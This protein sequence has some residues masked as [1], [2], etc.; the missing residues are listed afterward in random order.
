MR[1][2]IRVPIS[3]LTVNPFSA[4]TKGKVLSAWLFLPLLDRLALCFV[5][6]IFTNNARRVEIAQLFASAIELIRKN[7]SLVPTGSSRAGRSR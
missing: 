4:C 7:K 3:P 2:G 6:Q 5:P 1:C